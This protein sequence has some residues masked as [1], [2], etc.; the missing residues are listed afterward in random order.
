MRQHPLD[1]VE[2]EPRLDEHRIRAVTQEVDG[3]IEH[4]GVRL[5]EANRLACSRVPRMREHHA[6][7]IPRS[8][9]QDGAENP[10]AVLARGQDDGRGPISE[11]EERAGIVGRDEP[12]PELGDD[13][14]DDPLPRGHA[15]RRNVERR[16]EPQADIV[17]IEAV[18]GAPHV[19]RRH[20]V[21]G[22]RGNQRVTAERVDEDDAP[23]GLRRHA[24]ARQGPAQG[25]CS[26]RG[27][28]GTGR[29]E[30]AGGDAGPGRDA[31]CVPCA[32]HP[33]DQLGRRHGPLGHHAA[34][35]SDA[36]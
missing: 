29:D 23:D 30:V 32:R 2:P 20:D 19:E 27:G 26:E 13:D 9:S 15:T 6:A 31:S 1:V 24:S 16:E 36:H 18:A 8:I 21:V 5:R 10:L 4:A 34:C 11:D 17:Q 35:S 33:R 3:E 22:R 25:C 7:G 12:R 14:G 28:G